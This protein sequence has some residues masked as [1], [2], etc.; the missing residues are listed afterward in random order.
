[1]N[2]EVEETNKYNSYE[3]LD[4]AAM[5]C[6]NDSECIGIYDESCDSNGPFMHVRRGFWIPAYGRNCVHEKKKYESKEM[7]PPYSIIDLAVRN[8]IF[9][10][11]RYSLTGNGLICFDVYM[12]ERKTRNNTWSLGHCFQ[13]QEWAGPGTYTE[14]CCLSK[15]VHMFTCKTDRDKNDWSSNVVMLFG[16]RFCEDFVGYETVFSINILGR[17]LDGKIFMYV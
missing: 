3:Q 2:S 17:V 16:H 15:G 7:F 14:N 10:L 12:T 13:S 1:M 6:R 11:H 9:N 5:S 8:S 4:S